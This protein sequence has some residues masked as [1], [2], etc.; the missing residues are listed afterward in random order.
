MVWDSIIL[1]SQ[2]ARYIGNAITILRTDM[3][4]PVGNAPCTCRHICT[5]STKGRWIAYI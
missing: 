2:S 3:M 1:W 5:D 4:Y